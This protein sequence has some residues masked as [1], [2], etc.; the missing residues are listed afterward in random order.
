MVQNQNISKLLIHAIIL[1]GD[2]KDKMNI[3]T[4]WEPENKMPTYIKLCLQT[5]K[6]FLPEYCIN[7]VNYSNLNKY[8]GGSYFDKILFKDFSLPIQ[9]DAIRCALLHKFGGLW[10]DADTIITSPGIKNF[11]NVQSDLVMIGSHLAFIKAIKNSKII[12]I[13]NKEIRYKLLF[14]KKQKYNQ[15]S[16]LLIIDR[17]FHKKFYKNI[18]INNWDY[19]GNSILFRYLYKANPKEFISIN[20]F[21]TNALPEVLNCNPKYTNLAENY[22]KFY[23]Y[24][25]YSTEVLNNT[26]GIILLH[27]SWTPEEY[28]K[29]DEQEFLQQNNTISNILKKI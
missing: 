8:L 29:M 4:F 28:L 18:D 13:W 3:F 20:E 14:F 25:D 23:F 6:K 1:N 11:I 27:N 24:N 12:N 19:L 9:A 22:K 26:K 16:F 17:I 5:W 10:L 21:E 2:K 15:D 7:I